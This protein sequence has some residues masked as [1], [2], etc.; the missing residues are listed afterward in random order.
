VGSV[1]AAVP[2]L[3]EEWISETVGAGHVFLAKRR[4]SDDKRDKKDSSDKRERSTKH[5]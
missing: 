1:V 2:G 5:G 3:R 4:W